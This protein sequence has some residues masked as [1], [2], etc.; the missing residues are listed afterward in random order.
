VEAAGI[1]PSADIYATDNA[2]CN[3]EY[4][5]QCRAANALHFDCVKS[6]FLASLDTD[7]QRVIAGWERLDGTTRHAIAARFGQSD[8]DFG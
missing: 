8:M 3:C 2:L 1:E 5:Q 4:C 7:L 6:H